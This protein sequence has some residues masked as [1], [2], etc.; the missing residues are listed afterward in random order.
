MA[1][2]K[3]RKIDDE[4]R[5]FQE[6]WKTKYFCIPAKQKN[7]ITCLVCQTTISVMKEYNIRRHYET[8]HKSLDVLTKDERIEKLNNFTNSLSMQQKLFITKNDENLA[9]VTA[10]FK[11]SHLIAAS[12]RPFNDGQ[13]IKKCI[14]D[15]VSTILPEK[16]KLFENISLSRNTVTRRTEQISENINIQLKDRIKTFQYFSIA[17]DESTDVVDTAQLL[18]FIRG[19]DCDLNI[20]EELAELSSLYGSTTGQHIF[21]SIKTCFEK[22]QLNWENLFNVTTDGARSM[23]GDNIGLRGKINEKLASLGLKKPLY[24]HCIIHQYNLLA[25]TLKF[26]DVMKTVIS[27]VNF[28]RHNKLNHR[29]FRNFLDETDAE[30]DDV[31][32]FA[33]VR[34]LSKG[35]VL[36]RFFNLRKEIIT[37]CNEKNHLIPEL[38]DDVWLWKLAFLT[39]LVDHMNKYINKMQG[40]MKLVS[41]LYSNVQSFSTTLKLFHRQISENNFQHF[42][43]CDTLKKS[44]ELKT[45]IPINIFS[46]TIKILIRN[47]EERFSDFGNI[48]NEITLFENPFTFDVDEAFPDVQLELCQLQST[49]SLK[50]SFTEKPLVEFYKG[51]S[52]QDF[53]KL[54]IF[55]SKMLSI[56]GSSYICEQTYSKMKNAKT[57]NR[58]KLSDNHLRDILRIATS[59]IEPNITKLASSMQAHSSHHH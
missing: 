43:I 24:L 27:T 50:V 9:C 52:K 26:E 37:F 10:G 42:Q 48:S 3:K 6:I 54:R 31:I 33:E 55:A 45:N 36:L 35:K 18:I 19:V 7:A 29:E 39:D 44:G 16:V 14:I 34:W 2:N 5:N 53:P 11:L 28:I 30:W 47:M 15:A 13:F 22:L 21:D 23:T 58:N 59:K 56:F 38:E 12:G 1:F 32:Y 8:N 4:T 49:N 51:L 41:Q 17:L 46:D 25:K 40:N 57:N 20:T